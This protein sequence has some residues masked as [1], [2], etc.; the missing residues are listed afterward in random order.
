MLISHPQILQ[1]TITA[2]KNV[3]INVTKA[4]PVIT[5]SNP[6]D[7]IYGTA[8]NSTQLNATASV[9]GTLGLLYS[10]SQELY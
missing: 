6:A 5:W 10:S 7:I 9:T 4:T 3:T 1:T 8:L 2:S